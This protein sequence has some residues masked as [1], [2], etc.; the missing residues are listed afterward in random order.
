VTGSKLLLILSLLTGL[1]A[2]QCD[3]TSADIEAFYEKVTVTNTSTESY[4]FVGAVLDHSKFSWSIPAGV[5]RTA[6]GVLA[7]NFT[8]HVMAPSVGMYVS[9]RQLLQ[10]TRNTLVN[11][12]LDPSSSPDQ[13]AAAAADLL[14][15]VAA[16][17]QLGVESDDVQSCS[18]TIKPSV[19]SQATIG[20]T[21]T[22][23]GAEVWSVACN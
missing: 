8:V 13:V 1:I 18:G 14:V 21:R 10:D 15:V 12:S 23:D 9:Y 11:L 16:Q 22:T 5:S 7:T 3:I 19:E 6:S 20:Y 4:V 2:E 17:E